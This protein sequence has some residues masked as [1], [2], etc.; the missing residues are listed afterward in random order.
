MGDRR[1]QAPGPGTVSDCS[2]PRVLWGP[3]VRGGLSG[4]LPG[5]RGR[6]CWGLS[7]GDSP[8]LRALCGTRRKLGWGHFFGAQG[9]C[10]W[11]LAPPICISGWSVS[12]ADSGEG[13]PGLMGPA[14]GS[15]L[16]RGPRVWKTRK[17]GLAPRTE[18]LAP[19]TPHASVTSPPCR[20]VHSSRS[21]L[22]TAGCQARG[23]T[24]MQEP[25]RPS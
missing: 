25:R 17:E 22:S 12:A 14:R 1:G 23:P 24:R 15:P 3:G 13:D 20:S 18:S 19:P 8:S 2:R 9:A 5:R 6:L 7:L 11:G 21:R 16:P 4:A 10:L